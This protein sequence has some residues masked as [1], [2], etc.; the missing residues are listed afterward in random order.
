MKHG[1]ITSDN[2]AV[3]W[4]GRFEDGPDADAVAFETSINVDERMA[5]DDIRG[6]IAHAK[7]LAHSKIISQ[8]EA[9]EIVE[10]LTSIES[11]LQSGSLQIDLSAEDIHSFIEAALP[12]ALVKPAKKFTRDAAATTK[13]RLTNGFISVVLFPTCKTDF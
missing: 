9:D 3:L 8:S 11:D 6:S 4:H 1:A 2:H 10:G 5:L 12:T 7:M 13:L